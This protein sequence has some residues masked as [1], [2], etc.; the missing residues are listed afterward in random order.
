ML[1]KLPVCAALTLLS[2]LVFVSSGA[3]TEKSEQPV[4]HSLRETPTVQVVRKARDSIVSLHVKKAGLSRDIIGTGVI[5]DERGYLVTNRHV[6]NGAE[7]ITVRLADGQETLGDVYHQVASYDLAVVRI[8][9]ARQLKPLPLG[10]AAD[11]QVGE[12]VIAIGHP[13]GFTH[14]VSRGIVSYVGR[15]IEMPDG[16]KLTNLI[17]T[18]AAINPG[19]SGGALLNMNGELIG[20]NVALHD[21]ARGIGF[22][23]NADVVQ[24]VL[25]RDLSALKLYGLNHGLTCRETIAPEGAQ[26]Q[27]VVVQ[28]V[29][30]RTPAATAGLKQGDCLLRVGTCAVHN[31]FDVERALWETRGGVKIPITIIRKGLELTIEMTL[32]RPSLASNR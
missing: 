9:V 20:I 3:A 18:D 28:E 8:K 12:D 30:A 14:T 26:R 1:R 4:Y 17:Q 21:K 10:P 15:E 11:V 5:I 7:R 32:E 2:T 22:A 27:Q 13:Y 29:A 19:N 16:N 24:R 6:V 31:R 23:L 25:S